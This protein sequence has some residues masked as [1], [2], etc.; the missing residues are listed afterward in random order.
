M[1]VLP[2]GTG[3][4]SSHG[5]SLVP[6][7]VLSIL[8]LVVAVFVSLPSGVR[9]SPSTGPYQPH[10]P[11]R[12]NG[13]GEFTADNGVSGGS[14]TASD[15]FIIQGW[16]IASNAT[17]GIS[18]NNT[19]AHFIIRN[20]YV[21]STNWP[22]YSITMTNVTG[23]AVEDSTIIAVIAIGDSN[24]IEIRNIQTDFAGGVLYIDSTSGVQVAGFVGHVYV[25]S[26]T[27][28]S[29]VDN[30]NGGAFTAWISDSTN[31]S[32]SGDTFLCN[33]A[34][35]DCT[36]LHVDNSDNIT[37]TNN[38]FGVD[39]SIEVTNSSDLEISDNH[40]LQSVTGAIVLGS[41][42]NV[43]IDGN[44]VQD[45]VDAYSGFVKVTSCD[46]VNITGNNFS[47][48]S[49]Y[50]AGELLKISSSGNIA[51]EGNSFANSET[52][53][54]ISNTSNVTIDNNNIHSNTQGLVL[55]NTDH[56]QVFHNNFV[57]NTVQASEAYSTANTWD[58]GY[59]S[60]GNFWSDYTGVDNCS[61]PQQDI[62]TGP[63]GNGDTPYVFNDNQDNYPLM[64]YF[65]G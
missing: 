41:C 12:I 47:L 35:T 22:S 53:V 56:V 15:P 58:K 13:D 43:S 1:Y 29:M 49:D 55:N 6:Y 20:V 40:V 11:I 65:N 50:N 19:G 27:D 8:L 39:K 18:V 16:N 3:I 57:N 52:A 38:T 45:G 24:G 42:T 26:S 62:C 60:G 4:T 37:A 10:A 64:Q 17:P 5:F 32:L 63:D 7:K 54:T 34:S 14:G 28:V 36:G 61:G 44:Q 25:S 21:D 33:P 9:A 46:S 59:P 48:R 51:I 23:G 2:I 31:L 30:V